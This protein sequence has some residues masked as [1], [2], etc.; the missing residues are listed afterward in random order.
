MSFEA[1]EILTLRLSLGDI[2][3]E[4]VSNLV[5]LQLFLFLVDLIIVESE[6]CVFEI[7]EDFH[8]GAQV[9]WSLFLAEFTWLRTVHGFSHLEINFWI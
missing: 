7:L 9:D 4:G 2:E 6:L 5:E 3:E 8:F 1:V